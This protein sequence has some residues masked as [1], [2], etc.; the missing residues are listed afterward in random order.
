MFR[1]IFRHRGVVDESKRRERGISAA[2]ASASGDTASQVDPATRVSIP[3]DETMLALDREL[4]GLARLEVGQA[5]KERGWAALQ[6]ELERHPV[7]TAVPASTKGVA[8]KGAVR[9][10]A[11]SQTRTV[12]SNGMRWALGAAAAA[13]IVTA[14]VLAG[15]L[16]TSDD[17]APGFVDN[18]STTTSVISVAS[19]DTTEPTTVPTDITTVTT[20]P[21]TGTT[22][23]TTTQTTE[24]TVTTRGTGT[25]GGSPTTV[26]PTTTVTPSTG[27]QQYAAAQREG[28]ARAAVSH[29]AQLIIAGERS[30]A[31]GLVAPEAYGSLD[32]MSKS[33]N[34]PSGFTVTGARAISDDTLRVTLEFYDAE[35]DN[36]GNL[37]EVVRTFAIKVR[38]NDEGVMIIAINKG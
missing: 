22:T 37:T 5:A 34:H 17:G 11:G 14:A 8:P 1:D 21:V 31:R 7:R 30:G 28:D 12:R 15:V 13:V 29:L 6:R 35:T 23:D 26:T 38:A 36:D 2:S 27:E 9:V 20:E 18:G 4:S 25:T 19:S 3:V 16:A 32:Q 33:L 10:G 24:N